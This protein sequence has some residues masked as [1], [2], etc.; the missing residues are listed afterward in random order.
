MN[1]TDYAGASNDRLEIGFFAN[2]ATDEDYLVG[3]VLPSLFFPPL[4]TVADP[5][6]YGLRVTMNF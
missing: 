5:S 6:I 1:Y 4:L 3:G 2:N